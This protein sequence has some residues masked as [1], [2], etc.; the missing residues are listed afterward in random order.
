MWKNIVR[1]Y[2]RI[3]CSVQKLQITLNMGGLR[4]IF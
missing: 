3:R 2:K 4:L 1:E